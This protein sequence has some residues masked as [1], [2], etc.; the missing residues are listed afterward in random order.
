[1]AEKIRSEIESDDHFFRRLTVSVGISIIAGDRL[2][3]PILVEQAEKALSQAKS[4]GRNC[5]VRF[6]DGMQNPAPSAE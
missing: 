1:V 4:R 3:S 2:K 5:T 6:E